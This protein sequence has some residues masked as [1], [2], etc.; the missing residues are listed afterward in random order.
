MPEISPPGAHHEEFTAW[1]KQQGVQIN[2]VGPAIIAKH[3]LG[4]IAQR[5]V[6]AGE[7]LV[8]VPASVLLTIKTI[9]QNFRKLHEGITVHGLLA[10]FLAFGGPDASHYS[11]WK[12][13]WPSMQEFQ[14]S[15]PILWPSFMREPLD[16]NGNPHYKIGGLR[17]D[18]AF[19]IPPAIAGRWAHYRM[20]E[21]W[22]VRDT[23]P[24]YRQE[25]KLKA[26]W[27]IVS[28]VFPDQ[29]LPKYTYYWLIV[30][31]RSFYFELSG[32][33]AAQNHDDRM[34]L[35]PFVDYFN[36]N[37]HGV[38]FLHWFVIRKTRTE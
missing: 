26:D 36:H 21:F 31:T 30:N 37:D 18:P 34:V 24:M 20:R 13:T 1:A 22:K 25:K 16:N 29:T 19:I 2:G 3:G 28:K 17:E 9:P 38:S 8:D 27:D 23:A 33:E 10:S 35:C 5:R 14:E 11:R 15:M 4:I 32:R 7:V 12:N 6:E